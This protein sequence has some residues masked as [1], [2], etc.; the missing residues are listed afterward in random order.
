MNLIK[1]IIDGNVDLVRQLVSKENVNFHM[2]DLAT[3][4]MF[5]ID[6]DESEKNLEI[7]KILLDLGADVNIVNIFGDNSLIWPSYLGHDKIVQLLLAAGANP[8]IKNLKGNTPLTLA[9]NHPKILK[10]LLDVGANPDIQDADGDTALIISSRNN[11]AESVD[12]LL[13]AGANPNIQNIKGKT[14]L[15]VAADSA[16][17][18]VTEMLINYGADLFV[19]DHENLYALDLCFRD[20]CE[21]IISRAMWKKLYERDLD[22][23]KRYLK[24]GVKLDKNVLTM[25]LLNKRQQELCRK[26]SNEKNWEILYAFAMEFGMPVTPKMTKAQLCGIISKHLVR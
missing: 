13:K 18:D 12:I 9:V 14:A 6:K 11:I 4:L 21:E 3:P 15:M 16:E 25:I 1:A 10:L 26:L 22:T 23:V 24:L 2:E 8:N 19:K 7:V 17:E 20:K 5:I